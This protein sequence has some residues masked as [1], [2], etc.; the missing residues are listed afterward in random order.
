M[1]EYL[2]NCNHLIDW[3]NFIKEIENV[4]PMIGYQFDEDRS[5]SIDLAVVET[6]DAWRKAG[7]PMD[8]KKEDSP[9]A[10]E[11][12]YSGVH[13]DNVISD[14]ISNYLGIMPIDVSMVTRLVPGR[15]APWHWDIRD[16]K[17]VDK[18]NSYGKPIIRLH[19]HMNKPAPG[20]VFFVKE[21]CFYNEDQGSMYKWA[22]WRD[23]HAGAN[24]GLVS[25]YQ[26][27]IIGV[28]Q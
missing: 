13:F 17:T 10:W 7:Y 28:S 25:K 19:I 1:I 27:S 23:Y 26:F 16:K 20:H 8:N 5:S 24:C 9:I 11:A 6:A 3:D 2:G 12:W 21:H 15:F 4:K 22:D 18:F 14:K